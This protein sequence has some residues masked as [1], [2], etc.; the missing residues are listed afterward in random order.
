MGIVEIVARKYDSLADCIFAGV[1]EL[2]R[3][4]ELVSLTFAPSLCAPV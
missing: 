3:F 4:E 2:D 1:V